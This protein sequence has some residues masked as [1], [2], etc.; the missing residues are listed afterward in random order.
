MF[1]LGKIL[2]L[3][4]AAFAFLD[5]LAPSRCKAQSERV[6]GYLMV[7][8]REDSAFPV[9]D[10]SK[11]V[12]N[13]ALNELLDSFN[14]EKIYK[15]YPDDFTGKLREFY[16]VVCDCDELALANAIG[17]YSNL[18][19]FVRFE[20][21]VVFDAPP[22]T[23]PACP[24]DRYKIPFDPITQIGCGISD[25]SLWHLER[26]DAVEAWGITK[27]CPDVLVG[28]VD[29]NIQS[30]HPDFQ[31]ANGQNQFI[32]PATPQYNINGNL[33]S[34]HGTVVS[35]MV[36]AA[37]NNGRGVS[38]I[39]YRTRMI[40]LSVPNLHTTTTNNSVLQAINFGAKVI[41]CSWRN[42]NQNSWCMPVAD[43]AIIMGIAE[44]AG[45]LI[46][47]T[48]GNK[49][50]S[51]ICPNGGRPYPCSYP[52]VICVS[53]TNYE[54]KHLG[55][56]NHIPEIDIC[57]PGYNVFGAIT[58]E[59]PYG[60]NTGTSFAA[61][62]VAGTI[63]L[64]FAIDPTLTPADVRQV[65]S[66]S[67]DPIAD[68]YPDYVGLLGAGRIN[69]YKACSLTFQRLRP[70]TTVSANQTWT[71]VR[72]F[73]GD[74][75][76]R[77]GTTL[78]IRGTVYMP[79][80]GRITVER[81][82][83]L[84]V[85]EGRITCTCP[86]EM[87]EGIQVHGAPNETQHPIFQG[88]VELKNGAVVE[89]ARNGVS[90]VA[91]FAESTDV[92]WAETGGGIVVA[93]NAT[94]RNCK[95]SVGFNRYHA[96]P[97]VNG[98]PSANLSRFSNCT[99]ELTRP[100][101][102]GFYKFVSLWEVEGV[103]FQNCEFIN[104][105]PEQ[106]PD[107]GEGLF[108]IAASYKMTGCRFENLKRAAHVTQ[109][110]PTAHIFSFKDCTV[111]NCE[112]GVT[113]ENRNVDKIEGCTFVTDA[114][115][116]GPKAGSTILTANASAFNFKENV[117]DR[118]AGS[119]EPLEIG[120]INSGN[121]GATLFKNTI[122]HVLDGVPRSFGMVTSGH[123]P[124]IKIECNRYF[125]VTYPLVLN[126]FSSCSSLLPPFGSC[127][128]FG[129]KRDAGNR[130]SPTPCAVPNIHIAAPTNCQSMM[131]RYITNF[132]S[133]NQ[134]CTSFDFGLNSGVL[135]APCAGAG[136]PCIVSV[137]G[138]GGPPTAQ[139]NLA[140]QAL[141]QLNSITPDGGQT[142]MLLGQIASNTAPPQLKN[143]LLAH[144]PYLSD[145]VLA[146][147]VRRQSPP[148][149]LPML[150]DVLA[151]QLPLSP[152]V[153]RAIADKGWSNH[154][155]LKSLVEFSVNTPF[156]YAMAP[157]QSLEFE[158]REAAAEY[159]SAFRDLVEFYMSDETGQYYDDFI[160]LLKN[161]P[162]SGTKRDALK[163]EMS[164][165]TVAARIM[166]EAEPK[167]TAE[168][169]SFCDLQNMLLNMTREGRNYFRMT[170]AE[171]E[172]IYQLASS[173]ED[174][175]S[176]AVLEAKAIRKLL[177]GENYYIAL[178]VEQIEQN[179]PARKARPA[180]EKP[181]APSDFR[182]YPNPN[183]GVFTIEH[184]GG[185][186]ISVY[187]SDGRRVWRG[188]SEEGTVEVVLPPVS[189]MYFVRFVSGGETRTAKV[190]VE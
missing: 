46:T 154:P 128:P 94:F 172:K 132:D 21:E 116:E 130:F 93:D 50:P 45:V 48:P 117:A 155:Q 121:S 7:S 162:C 169:I 17:P 59:T 65:I 15:A 161:F 173:T 122:R 182:I 137:P 16:L 85:D 190:V 96:P 150:K 153:L 107:N 141:L 145:E 158:K 83:T 1:N 108:S 165:D 105:V 18:W 163:R 126:F 92:N 33:L 113:I 24:N 159:A 129:A 123:N 2:L 12:R 69:A 189:G 62:I 143:L 61:P 73:K 119:Y 168:E 22:D 3:S 74:I 47:A 43:Q 38:A 56:H 58:S 14:I 135:V 51:E 152:S 187:L 185:G 101:S 177:T 40:P 139:L 32:F 147:A 53:S 149:P 76:V 110:N 181:E 95:T 109:A 72:V 10:G 52:N 78:T 30:N 188:V 131:T 8:V 146:A 167:T 89:N 179:L 66:Q 81:G 67:G 79:A 160:E 102:E 178:P 170:P 114:N 112:Y 157:L 37:T 31:N 29:L 5:A 151:P 106:T 86:G 90:T 25:T 36:A 166:L 144:S 156:P 125:D 70:A 180:V 97:S 71:D 88:M 54:D 34:Y 4:T 176:Q 39:G 23:D 20:G 41:N 136:N 99:F 80:G 183:R 174:T 9:Y 49:S 104:R 118:T 148:L 35:G 77:S 91:Q 64:M 127:I 98:Q 55:L 186:E 57:A 42:S 184:A 171:L 11:T 140:Q 44:D 164:R 68:E 103:Q 115:F 134:G 138:P 6:P 27:G 75:T 120:V 87:W 84:I 28:I 124:A 100:V 82:A 26:I 111:L 13:D 63:A 175:L 142:D 19:T 133:P 60:E